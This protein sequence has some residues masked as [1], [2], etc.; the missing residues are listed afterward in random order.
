MLKQNACNSL[1][2]Y[3]RKAIIVCLV[4]SVGTL[5]L[6]GCFRF[7]V[8]PFPTSAM[9][10]LKPVVLTIIGPDNINAEIEEILNKLIILLC[11]LVIFMVLSLVTAVFYANPT[12]VGTCSFF[13]KA[14]NG[15]VKVSEV[16]HAFHHKRYG[17]VVRS[18]LGRTLYIYIACIC[19]FFRGFGILGIVFLFIGILEVYGIYNRTLVPFILSENPCL[20]SKRVKEISKSTMDGE[21]MPFFLL[22]LSFIGWFLL[23][24]ITLGVGF[25]FSIPYYQATKAEFYACMR[26]KMIAQGITTEEE[27][28]GNSMLGN[29]QENTMINV[30]TMSVSE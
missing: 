12:E 7:Y 13:R 9:L 23:S 25:I 8:L 14:R 1:N 4:A 10:Q 6:L 29:Q 22:Q 27:L 17:A 24:V 21:K 2:E 15:E 3:Y 18:M 20:S 16:F 5:L 26:E 28:T 30:E 11:K 19:F